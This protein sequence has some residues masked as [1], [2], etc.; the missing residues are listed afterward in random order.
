MKLFRIGFNINF[1]IMFLVL[2]LLISSSVCAATIHGRVYDSFLNRQNDAMVQ[3]DSVPRQFIVSKDGTYSFNVPVGTY[4]VY[5]KYLLDGE[6]DSFIEEEIV[7]VNEGD[8]V[9]D[10]ILFPVID[11]ISEEEDF[12]YEPDL[13]NDNSLIGLFLFLSGIAIFLLLIIYFYRKFKK[14]SFDDVFEHDNS[15]MDKHNKTEIGKMHKVDEDTSFKQSNEL[16]NVLDFIKK[17]GGRVTQKDI[18]KQFPSSEAK[19]SLIIT[20]LESKKL[21]R[22]IKKGRGNVIVL[23]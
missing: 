6:L 13:G 12:G 14:V 18:R 8:Y 1:C 20:E 3:I 15:E 5:A 10:L 2:L 23:N 17:N 21:V 19:I 11:N 4:K 9:L 7:V 16:E 22:K